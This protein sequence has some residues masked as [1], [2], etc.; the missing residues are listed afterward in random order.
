MRHFNFLA[1][2]L[3]CCA[4][5]ISTAA[6]ANAQ[7][8]PG[9]GGRPNF[10][11]GV[12]ASSLGAGVEAGVGFTRWMDVRGGFNGLNFSHNFDQDGV[13]YSGTLNLRSAQAAVD[14]KPF[15]D[16]FHVSPGVLLYNG[17]QITAKANVPGGQTFTL[18]GT[19]FQSD[20]A[21][22]INGTGKLSVK[23]AAPMV[24][25]GFGSLVP[26]K[27]HF[28]FYNDLGVV[29]QGEPQTTLALTGSACDA[30]TGQNCVNAA[31][32]P[33]ILSQVQAEQAKINKDTRIAKFYP[34][35]SFGFG[36]RF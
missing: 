35:L 6:T 21:N 26:H 33:T 14:F 10:A 32:D 34:V 11:I 5:L 18:G 17:N 30:A 36:Y 24:L 23:K 1:A 19:D 9:I 29:Y 22:P 28:T 25:F 12:K 13:T 27:H 15:G 16:W 4:L 31:T 7:S 20:P 2:F 8:V 3:F